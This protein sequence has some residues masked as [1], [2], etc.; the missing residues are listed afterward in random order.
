VSLFFATKVQEKMNTHISMAMEG[1]QAQSLPIR[2]C[3]KLNLVCP[4]YKL[5]LSCEVTELSVVMSL[6][7]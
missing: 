3:V 7:V 1:I 2:G 5:F 4:C 6:S